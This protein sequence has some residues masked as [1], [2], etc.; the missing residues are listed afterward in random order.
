MIYRYNLMDYGAEMSVNEDG[1]TR[2]YHMVF[3]IMQGEE[4]VAWHDEYVDWTDA[5]QKF[6]DDAVAKNLIYKAE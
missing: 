3:F 5:T 2:T 6:Y 4:I 1:S